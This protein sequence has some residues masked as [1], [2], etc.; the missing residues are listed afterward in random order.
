MA[1]EAKGKASELAGEARGAKE[2]AKG[3]A[4]EVAGEVKETL[5]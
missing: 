4:R 2:H 1:G 3:K 5:S